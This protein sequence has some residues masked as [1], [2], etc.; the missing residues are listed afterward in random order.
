L[1]TPLPLT[2]PTKTTHSDDLV[3][4]ILKIENIFREINSFNNNM[5]I[6]NNV[7]TS[8]FNADEK[9]LGITCILLLLTKFSVKNK[10]EFVN[11]VMGFINILNINI[12]HRQTIY[13]H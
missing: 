6:L 13:N 4:R 8:T 5:S 12:L 3:Q 1:C 11:T 9:K 2:S 7:C 10:V